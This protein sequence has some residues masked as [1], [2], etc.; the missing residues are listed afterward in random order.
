MK[1]DHHHQNV[2]ST[3]TS[4]NSLYKQQ[5]TM[6]MIMNTK[7]NISYLFLSVIINVRTLDV[8]GFS[9]ISFTRQEA[10]NGNIVA[11][12]SRRGVFDDS[13]DIDDSNDRRSF[14]DS[15][16]KTSVGTTAAALGIVS[17]PEK[18][19]ASMASIT[20]DNFSDLPNDAVRSYVQYR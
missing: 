6:N 18:S 8:L 1:N 7:I 13:D 5:I 15:I 10:P 16:L 4:K 17:F 2:H 11:V 19:S 9:P 20:D 3:E 12:S 14:V